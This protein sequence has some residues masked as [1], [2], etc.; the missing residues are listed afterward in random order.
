MDA[1]SPNSYHFG[2][3]THRK[4]DG[5]QVQSLKQALEVDLKMGK[6]FVRC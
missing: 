3:H 1:F 4:G 6:A 2:K 5:F